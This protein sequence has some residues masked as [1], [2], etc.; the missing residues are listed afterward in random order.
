MIRLLQVRY[1]RFSLLYK[2]FY[3]QFIAT[4]AVFVSLSINQFILLSLIEISTD[5][6]ENA[7]KKDLERIFMRFGPLKEIWLASYAPFYAFVVYRN[8]LDAQVHRFSFYTW[9]SFIIAHV[10][11]QRAPVSQVYFNC[12][13]SDLDWHK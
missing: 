1:C 5:L 8:R 3:K 7:R 10:R 6:D 2:Q 4:S 12:K 11:S 9:L 13:K